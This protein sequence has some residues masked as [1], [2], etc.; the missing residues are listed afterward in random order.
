MRS[1]F[2]QH[3]GVEIVTGVAGLQHI[4]EYDSV[5]VGNNLG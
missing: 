5:V 3:R 1:I 2:E 4:T